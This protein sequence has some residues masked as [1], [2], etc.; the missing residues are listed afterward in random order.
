MASKLI[1]FHFRH[2]FKYVVFPTGVHCFPASCPMILSSRPLFTPI[3]SQRG[4]GTSSRERGHPGR[5]TRPP[6]TCAGLGQ[7]AGEDR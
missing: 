6:G 4:E 5:V 2:N 1:L 3:R 7:R